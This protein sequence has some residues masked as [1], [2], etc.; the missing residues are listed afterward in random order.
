MARVGT[1]ADVGAMIPQHTR[2]SYFSVDYEREADR[3]WLRELGV[4]HRSCCADCGQVRLCDVDLLC[5][6]CGAKWQAWADGT[7]R[8]VLEWLSVVE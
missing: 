5:S 3:N 8:K 7:A 2:L 4:W 6:E 1:S